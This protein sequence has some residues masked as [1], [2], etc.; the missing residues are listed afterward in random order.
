M[1]DETKKAAEEVENNTPAE[2]TPATEPVAETP[3]NKEPEAATE[4]AEAPKA[5]ETAEEPAA[6]EEVAEAPEAAPAEEKEAPVAEEAAPEKAEA[7]PEKEEAAPVAEEAA[8][9]KA[10]EAAPVAEEVASEKAEATPEKT[11]EAPAKAE[12]AVAEKAEEAPAK[13]EA[14]APEFKLS[15]I[16]PLEDFD[17]DK[18][19]KQAEGYSTDERLKLEDIYDKTLT[20]IAEHEVVEGIVVKKTKKEVVVNIGYKS[21]GIVPVSEFRYNPDRDEGQQVEVYVESQEDKNGQL[22]LSHKK[23]RTLK[24]WDNVNNALKNEEVIKGFVKCRTKG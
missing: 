19:G 22:V 5:E 2:E 1:A 21:D 12:E 10:E 15:E 17:W 7:A 20:S 9:E 4:A 18:L 13:E 11:E 24:A 8:P 16:K 23:A 3:E 6:V 14:P